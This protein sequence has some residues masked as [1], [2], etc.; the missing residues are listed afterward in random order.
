[1]KQKKNRRR[2]K[3]NQPKES[4]FRSFSSSP[5]R[6]PLSLLIPTIDL[7]SPRRIQREVTTFVCSTRKRRIKTATIC[8]LIHHDQNRGRRNVGRETDTIP[9][10]PLISYTYIIQTHVHI[11]DTYRTKNHDAKP[12]PI[13]L[14]RRRWRSAAIEP[15]PNS[16]EYDFKSARLSN[17]LS[18]EP[19]A[20]IKSISLTV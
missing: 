15:F 4:L 20:S 16:S 10:T 14:Q 1:M 11:H 17:D 3:K 13:Y 19:F 5:R 18:Q 7:E 6:H 2:A 9:T 8:V 12:T